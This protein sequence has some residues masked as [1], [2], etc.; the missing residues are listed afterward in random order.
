MTYYKKCAIKIHLPL[1]YL[2][3]III[4]HDNVY[5]AVIM[6][7]P[8]REF[9][10]F[11]ARCLTLSN[12][13]PWQNW[14][15]AY[16]GYTLRMRTLFHGWPI[17]VNDTHTRRRRPG[18]FDECRMALSGRRPKTKPDDLGC[19]S[20]CTG[21]QSLHPP[22]PFISYIWYNK[23]TRMSRHP[24]QSSHHY[25]FILHAWWYKN[26]TDCQKKKV[27]GQG[28]YSAHKSSIISRWA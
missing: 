15:V 14:M 20:A 18:S 21:Y 6:A 7:E 2:L 13:A 27:K 25:A 12:P 11:I 17:M 3:I 5:G 22:S 26:T 23:R 1:P 16:L 19:E 8:L 24:I 28:D 9:T 10:R 4:T